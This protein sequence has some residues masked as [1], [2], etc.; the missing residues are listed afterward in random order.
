MLIYFGELG[1][2]S[3]ERKSNDNDYRIVLLLI[4][5]PALFNSR[6]IRNTL[7]ITFFIYFFGV[8]LY[9]NVYCLIVIM[10]HGFRNLNAL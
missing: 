1:L 6:D 9:T 4:G 2:V 7:W 3:S 8:H 10:G 5:S